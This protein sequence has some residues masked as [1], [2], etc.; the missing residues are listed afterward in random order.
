[1]R[2]QI[3]DFK[4][5]SDGRGSLISLEENRNIPFEIK[6]IYYLYNLNSQLVRGKHAHKSLK[7]VLICT[8]GNC[9]ILLDNGESKF[10]VNLNSPDKGLVI[11]NLIWREMFNFSQDCVI[12]VIADQHYDEADYIRN[13]DEFIEEV[14]KKS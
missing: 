7:Q 1:M 2:P 11:D 12:I 9:S 8:S 5:I 13:Y 10:E 4:V 6:R 3:L 14:K